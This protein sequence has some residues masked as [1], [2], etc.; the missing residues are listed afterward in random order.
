MAGMRKRSSVSIFSIVVIAAWFLSASPAKANNAV[1][2]LAS[3]LV[4]ASAAPGGASFTLTVRG[5]TF[6]SGATVYWNGSPRTTTF[7]T[8]TEL[9]A[10][11]NASDIAVAGSAAV[12]VWN[13]P[14]TGGFS[15]TIFFEIT[16]PISMMSFSGSPFNT[17]NSPDAVVTADFNGDGIQDLA[18]ANQLDNTVSI[19]LGVGN[20]TF[21]PQVTYATGDGPADV[22]VG[23]FNGDG[24]LD[25]A[26]V[27]SGENSSGQFDNSVS[28]LLGNGDGTFQ[29]QVTYATGQVPVSV[30]VGDFNRD[31]YLDLAIVDQY[32]DAVSIL[33]GN[34]DGTF[35]PEVE[36]GVSSQPMQVAVDDF[37]GDGRLDLVTANYIAQTVSILLGNGDGTFQCAS[38]FTATENPTAVATADF[39]G[40]GIR[41]L[42]VA[43]FG[44]STVSILIGNG[45]GTFHAQVRYATGT[46]PEAVVAEDFNGDGIL[47]VAL[48]TDNLQGSVSILLGNGDGT[49]QTTQNFPAGLLPV[50]ITAADYDNDGLMDITV[51]D[52]EANAVS[53][54]LSTTLVYSPTNLS[55]G[56]VNLGTTSSPQTV[57]LTNNGGSA[58]TITSIATSPA[59]GPFSQ[60]NTCGNSLAAGANCTVSVTFTPT[61]SG[62]VSGTLTITDSAQGSPQSV[63]LSGSGNGATVSFSP[64][65]VN[66]GN[67]VVN[68]TSAGQVVTMT[69]NGNATLN[70]TS[71]TATPSQYTI[72]STTCGST[73]TAGANCTFTVTF[74]PTQTGTLNG[75]IA[76]VDSGYGSPQTISLSGTGTQ[77][78]LTLSPAS[79]TFGVQLL[80]TSSAAQTVTAT[81]TGNATIT[82]NSI[83][84]L[85]NF[86]QTNNCGAALAVGASCS[87]NVTFTPVNINLLSGTFSIYDNAASS[88]QTIS[89]SGTGTQVNVNPSSLNF[90]T[91]SVGTTSSAMLVTLSNVGSSSVSISNVT[92]TG[93]NSTDFAQTNTCGSSVGP[94]AS[95][96]F[97]VTFTPG[98]A[99]TR[100]A[101]L[102]VYDS[103][104]ASPQ[105]VSLS[106]TGYSNGTGPAVTFNPTSL[107]FGNQNYKTK[108]A[109]M[110]VTLTNTGGATLDI[111]SITPSSNYSDTT[112]CLS[113]LAAG[114][115][116]TI[117]VSFTPTVVG[118]DN[119]SV[120]VVDNASNSP[121]SVSL[122]GT[123]VGAQAVLSPTTLTFGVQVDGTTSTAQT[124]TLTNQGNASLT[125]TSITAPANFTQTNDC[126]SSLAAG[127]SC[128][129]DVSFAPTGKGLL[130]GSVVVSDNSAGSPSQ[131][132]SVSGTG[133]QMYVT[134]SSLN[135]G[136]INIGSSSSPQT[137]SVTNE[138]TTSVSITGVSVTG[139]NSGDFVKTNNCGSTLGAGATCTVIVTFTPA[140]SGNRTA[141]LN[142]NDAGGASPQ[143]V[144]LSGTGNP[145]G[146]GPQITLNPTSLSFGSQNY[147]TASKSQTVTV[148]STGTVALGITGVT[149]SQSDF[150]VTSNDCPTSL[151]PGS[152]CTFTVSFDPQSVGAISG[153]ASVTDNAPN[154]PQ[155][156][157]LSGT[158][159]GAFPSLTPATLTFS[160]QVVNTTSPSQTATLSNTGNA[161][162]TINSITIPSG[163]GQTNNC[164]S[165]L[166]AGANCTINVT[167]TPTNSGMSN[168][169]LVVSDNGAGNP[170]QKVSLSGTGTYAEL[171]PTSLNFG[172]VP[173]GQSSTPQ[174]VTLINVN[175]ITS[176]SIS[177]MMFTGSDPGDFS[178]TN[179]CGKSLGAGASCTITVTFTPQATGSRTASL[180]IAD[181]A[182]GSPQTVAVSGTGE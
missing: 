7:V 101:T 174:T 166:A 35:Q 106:G 170:S 160:T 114:Q 20:G 10:T 135:F 42:A 37:N 31:G 179:N 123:G 124:A 165:S 145:S 137:V 17:G 73:L 141:T 156:V 72:A 2:F 62:N 59:N 134:P 128:A 149:T 6:V 168:G 40:D 107:S 144:A 155:T 152:S 173:V 33:L 103:G 87:I 55:F 83:S 11:I 68:A 181:G 86:T 41:D 60:T 51:P 5:G 38:D 9:T 157:M 28:I 96:A 26:V 74:D 77:G 105:A 98:A 131:K 91:I 45:D 66:F 70:I 163:F 46:Y 27:N 172:T 139:T 29:A 180:S 115:S 118:T 65:S 97:S 176:F 1:P 109:V 47:D 30:A 18:V 78:V 12:Q 171:S 13:P 161:S 56:T 58:V 19:L 99:G 150:T 94:N 52:L 110:K 92:I 82:I 34:G 4:P 159:L 36:Y 79:L 154:S 84:T 130:N 21:Q 167:F 8:G 14:P 125:I 61:T 64:S 116:C 69:N 49:L 178:Q 89:V 146:T 23:D 140:G 127:A 43:D 112:T 85:A 95:C 88:P 111:T 63:A 75:S 81:N 57:T 122:T 3:P 158:G 67:Q 39:N 119:G 177:S 133:T 121:Q 138:G 169:S 164:G 136:T 15:N 102:S 117:S 129:I 148:T 126:E 151:Y 104:G 48:P 132:V 54:L 182:G 162:L 175:T 143:T 147:K 142:I 71:I 93:T 120:T 16:N 50:S 108:S 24:H 44:S 153:T 76:V 25:L 22:A 100:T 53:V 32:D 90:G 113:T 80:N